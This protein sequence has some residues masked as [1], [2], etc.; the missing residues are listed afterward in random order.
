MSLP[1]NFD[2]ASVTAWERQV[3]PTS[4]AAQRKPAA[5]T[6]GAGTVLPHPQATPSPTLSPSPIP[7]LAPMLP[8]MTGAGEESSI[9]VTRA[10]TTQTVQKKRP[11][12]AIA[13]SGWYQ[14][15][16]STALRAEP[17]T[18]AALVALLKPSTRV[19]VVGIVS[20]TGLEVRSVSNR[21]PGYLHRTDAQ[22]V[23]GSR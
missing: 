14:I 6:V 5:A 12:R 20:G 18:S 9:T 23:D 17:R 11:P 13:E 22:R 1:P 2:L 7:A 15:K 10:K 3:V 16:R 8:G 19:R 4:Y 21:R